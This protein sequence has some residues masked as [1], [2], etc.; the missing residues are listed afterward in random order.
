MNRVCLNTRITTNYYIVVLCYDV[1]RKREEI[2][3]SM[4][5]VMDS[6]LFQLLNFIGR[7]TFDSIGAVTNVMLLNTGVRSDVIRD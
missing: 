3:T 2:K 5:N 4:K 7:L 1:Y 6:K